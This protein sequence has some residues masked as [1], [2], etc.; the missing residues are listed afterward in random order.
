MGYSTDYTLT[1]LSK[2]TGMP[3]PPSREMM[4]AL[5]E[6]VDQDETGLS[7][8]GKT[9][10]SVKWYGCGKDLDKLSQQ[11]PD[12][13]FCLDCLGEDGD[14]WRTYAS[15]G[16]HYDVKPEIIFPSFASSPMKDLTLG[17]IVY[18]SG[19][20][21]AR[22]VDVENR[23]WEL[24]S[25]DHVF[26]TVPYQ[27]RDEAIALA[28]LASKVKDDVLGE[29]IKVE[30]E[31]EQIILPFSVGDRVAHVKDPGW[32]GTVMSVDE[33]G[34]EVGVHWDDVTDPDFQDFQR[35]EKLTPNQ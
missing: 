9:K 25:G 21:S 1:E 5:F 22:L 11:F 15:N 32:I 26:S 14:R 6:I 18:E 31:T 17:E 33:Y 35:T 3:Q 8:T 27:S 28:A 19:S 2:N 10:N 16:E 7:E 34:E 20:V 24:F 23:C 12:A 4:A 13:V 29:S 30:S